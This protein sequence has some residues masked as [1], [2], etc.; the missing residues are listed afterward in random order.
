MSRGLKPRS[1]SGLYAVVKRRSSTVVQMFRLTAQ[2]FRRF[3][4]NAS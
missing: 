4:E 1:F 2:F 3:R